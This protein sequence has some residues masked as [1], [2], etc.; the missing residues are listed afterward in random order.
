VDEAVPETD[1]LRC[2]RNLLESF[3]ISIREA[4][5]CLSDNLELAFHSCPPEIILFIIQ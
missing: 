4:I 2:L 1:D 5:T 3:G